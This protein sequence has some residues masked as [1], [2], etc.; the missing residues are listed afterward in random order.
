MQNKITKLIEK[1]YEGNATE[2]EEE[3]LRKWL[4]QTKDSSCM[5]LQQYFSLIDAEQQRT[6]PPALE[7]KFVSRFLEK[8][9][10]RKPLIIRIGMAASV[11]SLI[12][13]GIMWK[14]DLLKKSPQYS[15]AE[16]QQSYTQ[17]KSALITM[18]AY[19]NDGIQLMRI[20]ATMEKPFQDLHKLSD[21]KILE[22]HENQ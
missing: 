22:E 2:Q 7:K 3:E 21:I 16:I 19:L 10:N 18:S 17:A 5:P 11:A 14:S 6:L 15:E 9:K 12:L 20:P 13:A 1:F 4:W 8:K